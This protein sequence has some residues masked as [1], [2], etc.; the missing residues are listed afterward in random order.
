MGDS[1]RWAFLL[2]AEE[3]LVSSTHVKVES[4]STVTF[5][6]RFAVT[7][8]NLLL[9]HTGGVKNKNK[10]KNGEMIHTSLFL[11]RLHI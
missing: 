8:A 7:R 10:N 5:T 9:L 1:K 2:A 3:N 6:P 4:W 11:S